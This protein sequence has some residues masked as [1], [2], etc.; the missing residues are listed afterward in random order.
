VEDAMNS[1]FYVLGVVV[2]VLFVVG[3]LRRA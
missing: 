1:I 2:V 3:F